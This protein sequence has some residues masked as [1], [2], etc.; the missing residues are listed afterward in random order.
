MSVSPHRE[1]LELRLKAH[2]DE[3]ERQLR[4]ANPQELDEARRRFRQA[5]HDFKLLVLDGKTPLY[6]AKR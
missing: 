1:Q 2:L 3:A 6:I 5:L 4:N